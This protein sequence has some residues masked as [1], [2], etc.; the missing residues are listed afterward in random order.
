MGGQVRRVYTALLDSK[1]ERWAE[2]KTALADSIADMAAFYQALRALPRTTV[3]PD[4]PEWFARLL[5]QVGPNRPVAS[6]PCAT[7]EPVGSSISP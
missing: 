5:Q 6:L 2:Q 3:P 7:T 4:M 1:E